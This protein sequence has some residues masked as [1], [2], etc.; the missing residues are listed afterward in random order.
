M[1]LGVHTQNKFIIHLFLRMLCLVLMLHFCA[2]HCEHA[3]LHLYNTVQKYSL[4]KTRSQSLPPDSLF[5]IHET[6][7]FFCKALMLHNLLVIC[8]SNEVSLVDQGYTVNWTTEMT[9]H[10]K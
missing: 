1:N 5:R 10:I 8:P 9:N 4:N 7:N 2:E 3:L 6:D